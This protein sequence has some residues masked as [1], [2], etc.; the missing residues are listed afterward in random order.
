MV[1]T[2]KVQVSPEQDYRLQQL[3]AAVALPTINFH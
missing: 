2:E 3:A 1:E